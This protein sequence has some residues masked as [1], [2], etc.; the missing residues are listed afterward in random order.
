MCEVTKLSLP[1]IALF[2]S[3]A[4][5][6]DIPPLRLEQTIPL[7]DVE[8]RIDHFSVDVPNQRLFVAALGNNTVEVLDLKAGK[9]IFSIPDL[10][11]PQGVLFVPPANKLFV[12]SAGD[13]TCRIFDGDSFDLINVVNF[14][15][16][17]DNLR[18]DPSA[19]QVYVGYGRGALGV[20]D[21]TSEEVVG[22][23]PVGGHPE[24]FQLER[25]GPR[26]FVNVPP[27]RSIVVVD[28]IGH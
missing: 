7:P 25:L 19:D 16:D 4:R 15:D 18:Y 9:R 11:E 3:F 26:V 17:A 24:A 5:A 20:I 21:A 14:S 8:G 12:A 28:R 1:A 22:D 13:G 2:C 10:Q 6:G 23:I 27:I